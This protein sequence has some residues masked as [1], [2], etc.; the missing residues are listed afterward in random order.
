MSYCEHS[1]SVRL[2]ALLLETLEAQTYIGTYEHSY[3]HHNRLV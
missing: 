3:C 2:S 1:T